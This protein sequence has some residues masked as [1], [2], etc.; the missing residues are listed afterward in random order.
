MRIIF[1]SL[2]TISILAGIGL[3]FWQQEWQFSRPTPVPANYSNVQS[4]DSISNELLSSLNLQENDQIFIHFYNFD[5]PC[6]RFN[7]KEFQNLVIQFESE[8]KFLAV[9]ET[10]DKKKVK[11]INSEK[12]MI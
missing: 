2:L 8:V 10:I 9:L 3:I 6:S 1:A 11:S 5:C 7:I 4:G 12:N